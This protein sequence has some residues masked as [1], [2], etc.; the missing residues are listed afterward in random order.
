MMSRDDYDYVWYGRN[1]ADNGPEERMRIDNGEKTLDF[2][3]SAKIRLQGSQNHGQRLAHINIGSDGGSSTDT[4]AI[5]IWGNWQNQESKSITWNHGSTI[6]NMIAQQRVR[7]NSTPSSTYYEIGRFYHGQD[8]S[9]YPIRF[10]STSTTTANL[11]LDGNLIVPSGYGIDFSATS[12]PGSG[13][14]TSELFDD[15]EEGTWTPVFSNGGTCSYSHQIGHYTKIGN[16]VQVTVHLDINGV[17]TASGD[18]KVQ[19]F[20]FTSANNY[21]EY[22]S[23]STVH[24]TGW[25]TARRSLNILLAQNT[26]ITNPLYHNMTGTTSSSNPSITGSDWGKAS[27][28]DMGGG[29]LL[30]TMT[31]RAA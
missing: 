3:S 5:D 25:T 19:G 10:V 18:I 7:Y 2:P 15:Y 11:E 23:S 14:G 20:P 4:R 28:A 26:T 21:A 13:T 17:G 9:A 16:L 12:G 1:D 6:T 30:F 24:G 29:N 22:A 27:H 8:T 31:Y